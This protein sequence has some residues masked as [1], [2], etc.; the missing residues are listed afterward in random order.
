LSNIF[1]IV[2]ATS[3]AGNVFAS[4]P[5]PERSEIAP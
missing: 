1:Q 3:P 2:T 5:L 4:P